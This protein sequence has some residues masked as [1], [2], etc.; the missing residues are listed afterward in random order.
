MSEAEVIEQNPAENVLQAEPVSEVVAEAPVEPVVEPELP[1]EDSAL[2]KPVDKNKPKEEKQVSV[3]V[4]L[5]RIGAKEAQRQQAEEQRLAAERKAQ[6][7]QVMIERL[8]GGAKE[9]DPQNNQQIDIERLVDQRVEQRQFIADKNSIVRAGRSAFGMSDFDQLVDVAAS[10]GC[11]T[12]DFIKSVLAVDRTNAHQIFA[13]LGRQP[14]IAAQLAT[15]D[16]FQRTAELTRLS[17]TI[18]N[19]PA[20]KV[21]AAPAKQVS[22][23]PA[24]PPPVEPSASKAVDW[25]KD[26]ASDADFDAGFKEMMLK[27]SQRR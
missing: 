23:A 4:M 6:D 15:L 26:E 13:E 24:P 12:D 8:Q 22:R 7:L 3:K 1:L 14:E 11:V 9:P 27:R 18:A 16:P 5:D 20:S 2:T 10:M 21:A 19:P 25:R 17:M